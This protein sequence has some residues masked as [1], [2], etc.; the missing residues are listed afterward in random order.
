MTYVLLTA[1]VSITHICDALQRFSVDC[2][3]SR[4]AATFSVIY[5][6]IACSAA[7]LLNKG[8]SDANLPVWLPVA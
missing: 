3:Y 7:L 5:Y 1:S 6:F 2:T 4:P 8:C